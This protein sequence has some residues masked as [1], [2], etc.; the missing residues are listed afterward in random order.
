MDEFKPGSFKLATKSKVP[1]VPVTLE[2]GY[3]AF[4]EKGGE[5]TPGAK[6]TVVF[7]KPIE[8]KNLDRKQLKAVPE[9]TEKII[10]NNLK[11]I[12]MEKEKEKET[13]NQN[14]E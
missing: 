6:I 4:E 1:V 5:Y 10:R 14:A 13:S 8:T 9:E 3:H 7:D 12:L 2:G 11:K